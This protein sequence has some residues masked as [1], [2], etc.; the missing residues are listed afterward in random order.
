MRE[1]LWIGAR[2]GLCLRQSAIVKPPLFPD[3]FRRSTRMPLRDRVVGTQ[4]DKDR[5]V[6]AQ[7]GRSK[8]RGRCRA[9]RKRESA[10]TRCR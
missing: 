1:D 9:D 4:K 5:Q 10:N 6:E 2:A 7:R 3:R 8:S